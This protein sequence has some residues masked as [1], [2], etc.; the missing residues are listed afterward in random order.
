MQDP[1]YTQACATPVT[2]LAPH[3]DHALVLLAVRTVEAASAQDARTE[4]HCLFKFL[5]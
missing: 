2:S 4:V 5:G 3:K 1:G